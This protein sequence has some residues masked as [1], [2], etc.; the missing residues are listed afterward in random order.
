M[1]LKKTVQID[2][3]EVMFKASAAVP[4]LYRIKFQRDIYRDMKQLE[5]AFNSKNEMDSV[6]LEVFENI[7]YIFAWH[8]DPEHVPDQPDKWLEQFNMFSI[9]QVFPQILD[10]WGINVETEVQAKKNIIQQNGK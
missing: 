2:D 3:K 7:A 1:A 5:T 6:N 4:R 8:A 9:Y 10:L